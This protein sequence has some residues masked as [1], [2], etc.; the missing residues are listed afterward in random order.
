MS[1]PCPAVLAG[2]ASGMTLAVPVSVSAAPFSLSNSFVNAD[3][4]VPFMMG[5]VTGA[6]MGIAA[7]SFYLYI[8]ERH[9]H[10]EFVISRGQHRGSQ[11]GH[12][13]QPNRSEAPQHARHEQTSAAASHVDA[14]SSKKTA[15]TQQTAA[16]Q[17]H[18]AAH[19]AKDY[20]EI[21]E[22]YVRRAGIVERMATRARGVASVLSDRLEANMMD[23]VPVIERADGSVGDVGTTWW[24]AAVQNSGSRTTVPQASHATQA[25]VSPT[26]VPSAQV[27]SSQKKVSERLA[28]IDFGMFPEHRAAEDLDTNTDLWQVALDALDEQARAQS[29][30]AFEDIVGGT[31]T[32][33]EPDGLEAPTSF[34]PFKTPAGHPEVVDTES[35]V[36]YLI[37]DEFSRNES[38]S[39]RRNAREYL[40]VI[41]GGTLTQSLFG[42]ARRSR[43]RR[44]SYQPRHMAA[45]AQQ[46]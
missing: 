9:S 21:A 8:R 2:L 20:G 23:G 44:G 32:L 25:S 15:H 39:A 16:Q 30:F 5:C 3:P 42:S 10:D 26:Q 46:A 35:Y 6:A 7:S 34:I 37:S 13:A 28:D 12:F 17:S 1:R 4:V 45:V 33:D 43:G 11:G 14:S 24:D 40:H 27:S 38:S 22:N 18:T 19:S 29:P 31:D 36:D 41:E